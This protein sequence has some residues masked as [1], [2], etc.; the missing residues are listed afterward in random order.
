M[1]GIEEVFGIEIDFYVKLN[2]F[3]VID[4]IDAIGEIEV[5]VPIEFC[6]QDEN[7]SFAQKDLI[8]LKEGKQKVNGKQALA[9]S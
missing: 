8:C 5:D 3:S 2:F 7:R 4:I 6:E 9:L 1:K